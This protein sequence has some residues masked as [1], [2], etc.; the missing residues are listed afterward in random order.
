MKKI[1]GKF[2]YDGAKEETEKTKMGGD[3]G[4][5]HLEGNAGSCTVRASKKRI[6]I[7]YV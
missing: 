2:H 7:L 3:Q 4:Q 6:C 5:R 1:T